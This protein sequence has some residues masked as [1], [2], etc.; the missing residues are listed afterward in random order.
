[1]S[2]VRAILVRELRLHW[3]QGNSA[4]MAIAFLAIVVT[5]FPLGI[6]P[7]LATLQRIGAGVIWVAV[8]LS[9]LLSLDRLFHAD[10]E[11][12]SMDTLALAPLPLE[13][14]VALKCLAHWVAAAFPLI[15]ASPFLALLMNLE[16]REIMP[17]VIGLLVGSP[18]LTLIGAIGAGLTAG[19]KRGG[20]IVALLIL[21][22]YVPT[23]IFGVS[24][25]DAVTSPLSLMTPILIL[26]A[27]SLV[28]LALAPIAAAAAL[29]LTLE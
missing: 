9:T 14:I 20:V 28:A 24:A 21:P 26:A 12:G 3:R 13:A 17:L 27:I 2:V 22:L 19:L 29:R 15:L 25:V 1:M 7:E 18:A 10:V 11:D 8:L 5:L 23:L 6:G 4:A 16:M